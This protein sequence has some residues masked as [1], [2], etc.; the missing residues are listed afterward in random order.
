MQVRSAD[1]FTAAEPRLELGL[2]VPEPAPAAAPTEAARPRSGLRTR[3]FSFVALALLAAALA[4][5]LYNVYWALKDSFVAPAILTADSE[6]V[7]AHKLK[8]DE[9][10]VERARAVAE[11]EGIDA[12]LAAAREATEHLQGVLRSISGGFRAASELTARRASDGG[13]QL[14]S[15]RDQRSLLAAMRQDQARLAERASAEMESGVVSRSDAAREQ[16]VLRQLDVALL[17]NERA[18]VQA[19]AAQHETGVTRRALAARS[20]A[21]T[22]EVAAREEQ[23]IRVELELMR[24]ASEVRSRT[25][26][27]AA[28]QLRVERIDEVVRQLASR[29]YVRA[30]QHKLDVA[31]VPYTQ[32][33]GVRA[34]A[35][36]YACVWGLAL[37][38]RVGAVTDVIPGEVVLPDPWGVQARGQY[39]VLALADPEAARQ[40]VLRIRPAGPGVD[41]AAAAAGPERRPQAQR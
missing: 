7:L 12:A 4:G 18:I 8:L 33:D 17:E 5:V 38:R 37:C 3:L 32:L 22:F 31:F 10:D 30:A 29:P 15:L 20:G 1:G 28:L 41:G 19:T 14:K 23:R 27:R 16:Q 35:N 9:L 2:P 25:A 21:A 26:Q 13:A 36:V 34:G 24:V 11:L 6:I 40:K 39:A